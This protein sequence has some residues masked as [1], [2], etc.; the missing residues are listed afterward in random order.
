M[1]TKERLLRWIAGEA[2]VRAT[3]PDAPIRASG[4]WSFGITDEA[5]GGEVDDIGPRAD[6]PGVRTA[7]TPPPPR[8]RERGREPER[9]ELPLDPA[10]AEA[11]ELPDAPEAGPDEAPSGRDEPAARE[12]DLVPLAPTEKER[13][14]A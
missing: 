5:Q 11:V 10:G 4:L 7:S 2:P 3:R 12:E 14:A 13:D 9:G 6:V 1:N 8:P